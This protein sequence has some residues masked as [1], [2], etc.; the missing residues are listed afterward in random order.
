M[1]KA[2][3]EQAVALARAVNY[4]SAGT[5]EFVSPARPRSSTS[6]K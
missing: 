2:M 6:W 5:V 1:R 3:G 4:E